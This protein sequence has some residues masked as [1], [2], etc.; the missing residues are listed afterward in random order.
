MSNKVRWLLDAPK[1]RG[2]LAECGKWIAEVGHTPYSAGLVIV[3]YTDDAP[4][5]W[6]QEKAFPGLDDAITLID[7]ISKTMV[8]GLKCPLPCRCQCLL[9]YVASLNEGDFERDSQQKPLDMGLHFWLLPRYQHDEGFLKS[10][11]EDGTNN[12]GFAL[13]AEWR[14]QFLLKEKTNSRGLFPVPENTSNDDRS[15]YQEWVRKCLR[16]SVQSG[17]SAPDPQI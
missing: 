3:K 17:P 4:A 15:K 7:E 13:M 10:I 6:G 16:E 12:D 14:K 2:Q 1:W 9:V 11:N 8:R 5:F